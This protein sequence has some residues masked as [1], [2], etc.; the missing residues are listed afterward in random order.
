MEKSALD[1]LL[2]KLP[3]AYRGALI[4]GIPIL[5]TIPAIAAWSWSSRASS[6]AYWW[7][8][9][10]QEVIRE[11][12]ILSRKLSDG[13][14]QARA[15]ISGSSQLAKPY[16]PIAKEISISLENLKNLTQDNALQQESLVTI[17]KQ[18]AQ[19]IELLTAATDSIESASGEGSPNT[20][21]LAGSQEQVEQLR[22]L[23]EE[24]K[25]QEWKLLS[26]RQERLDRIRT[27]TNILQ[28]TSIC[29]VLLSYG[30]AIKLYQS[31]EHQLERRAKELKA[32]NDNLETTNKLVISRNQELDKFAY[33]VSHDLKA[34]LR[35][36]S[37]IA[38]W[39]EED[40]DENLEPETKENLALLRSRVA[41]MNNFI[42]SLLEYSRA[43]RIQ[44]EK[45]TVD[46][47]Q[48]LHEI[49]DS[50]SPPPEFKIQIQEPM[51]VLE[52]EALL[53]Q[54]IFSNLISNAVKHHHRQDG[55]VAIL[56]TKQPS[57]Y[58]FQVK[59][60]GRGIAKEHQERIFEVFQ[61]LDSRDN[62][63][64]TGIGLS[65]VRKIVKN[66]GEEI[67]LESVPG[68]GTSF[69]FTW[70]SLGSPNLA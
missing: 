26:I 36:I 35:A 67:W 32:L 64:N 61:T 12:N 5:S 66:Q 40:L 53:L 43:G 6:Q 17:E 44:G 29:L 63:E 1:R 56:A 41:R 38:S 13:E 51:P 14:V 42:D 19:R 8:N 23:I 16:E 22:K 47:K 49:V 39:I 33:I 28:G 34:P 7:V 30:I 15:T 20:T 65:I 11:S 45:T 46:V 31:S 25:Q 2:A 48:L 70:D 18:I 27:V 55:T 37:N 60:D 54:Q 62:K 59:D 58:L 9:H 24:F 52:T 4:V 10:T 68:E 21:L 3:I 69:F 57:S 50:V